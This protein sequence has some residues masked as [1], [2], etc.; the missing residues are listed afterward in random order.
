MADKYCHRA[1]LQYTLCHLD[2]L[3]RSGRGVDSSY[4]ISSV[5]GTFYCCKWE[6]IKSLEHMRSWVDGVSTPLTYV[7]PTLSLSFQ[8]SGNS[9]SKKTPQNPTDQYSFLQLL[10]K[11]SFW[12]GKYQNTY[13]H[14][15]ERFVC[16][17]HL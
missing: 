10:R 11:Y 5:P 14:K 9:N 12:T 6:T 17:C 7:T 16:R 13:V 1:R 4:P 3:P 8:S 15:F 2:H